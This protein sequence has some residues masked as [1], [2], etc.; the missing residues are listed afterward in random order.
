MIDEL[1]VFAKWYLSEG[2]KNLRPPNKSVYNYGVVVSNVLFRE[3]PFQVEMFL[4]PPSTN[5]VLNEH[6]HPN[7]DSFELYLSGE[8][9]FTLEGEQVVNDQ[10][11]K[12]VV[13]GSSK[14]LGT[15]IRVH[16]GVKHGA[17]VGNDGG[18]FIS[19]QHWLNGVIPTSVGLDWNSSV[20][21]DNYQE[22]P[23]VI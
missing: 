23:K 17:K 18:S 6:S 5:I 22:A 20:D 13:D 14:M 19:I 21:G 3:G 4:I 1:D 8:I 15:L 9:M 10:D 7:V 11:A 2:I 12:S 16:P